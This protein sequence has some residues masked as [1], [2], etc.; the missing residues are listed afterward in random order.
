MAEKVLAALPDEASRVAL[1]SN[2]VL[3]AE[4]LSLCLLPLAAYSPAAVAS[5]AA[6]IA[7][8][9]PPSVAEPLVGLQP[10]ALRFTSAVMA[11]G[12]HKLCLTPTDGCKAAATELAGSLRERLRQCQAVTVG[13]S[14]LPHV[15]VIKITYTQAGPGAKKAKAA[16]NKLAKDC[17]LVAMAKTIALTDVPADCDAA[18]QLLSID[19]RTDGAVYPSPAADGAVYPSAAADGAVYPSAAALG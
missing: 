10:T 1:Q 11:Y 18:L 5:V 4:R 19:M 6:A 16:A 13:P 15:S 2:G 17:G 9:S 3:P 12:S 8:S 7:S 14:P